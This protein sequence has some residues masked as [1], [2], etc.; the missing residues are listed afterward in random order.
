[1]GLSELR[2]ISVGA[3][4]GQHRLVPSETFNI[5]LSQQKFGN[6]TPEKGRKKHAHKNPPSLIFGLF[7]IFQATPHNACH[8]GKKRTHNIRQQ[9]TERFFTSGMNDAG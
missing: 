6:A 8:L 1:M 3:H 2:M 5:L 4:D 9:C 7:C